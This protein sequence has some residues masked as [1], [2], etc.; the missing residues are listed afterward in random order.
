MHSQIFINMAKK[1]QATEEKIHVIEDAL[2]KTE[3]FI[4]KN[5]KVLTIILGAIIVVVLGIFA[6][7]KFYVNP[8]SIEAESQIFMAQKYFEIDSLDKALY[9][10]GNYPGFI[11]VSETYSST[12]AGNLAKYYIGSIYLKQGNYEEA[13]K[14][15]KKF[16]SKDYIL[17]IMAYGNIGDAYCELNDLKQAANYYQKAYSYKPNDLVTPIYLMRAAFVYEDM[18][19]YKKAIE[20][21]NKIKTEHH[22]SFEARNID[23]YIASAEERMGE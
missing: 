19:D 14:Y 8:R 21:Y 18:G 2:S 7:Q 15:L 20:L 4:E 11:D 6:F 17:R 13:V 5:Q 9:G 23:K 12:K 16:K 3:H 22:M 10:D 1:K